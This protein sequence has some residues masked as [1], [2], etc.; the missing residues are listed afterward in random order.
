MGSISM[1][2]LVIFLM[3]VRKLPDNADILGKERIS[4]QGTFIEII[5]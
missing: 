5:D 4:I 2:Y 3:K 1:D